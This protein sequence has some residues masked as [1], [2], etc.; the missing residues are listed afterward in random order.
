MSNHVPTFSAHLCHGNLPVAFVF[1]VPGKAEKAQGRPVAEDTGENLDAA[2]ICLHASRPE[3][4]ASVHRY[5]YR[6]T[7]AF[8]K[9][10]AVSLGNAKSE[11][12][13]SE[14]KESRNVSRVVA[15]LDGCNFVILCG[16]K[17][18]LLRVTIAAAGRS[19]IVAPHVGNKG[20]NTSFPTLSLSTGLS[21]AARRQQRV[22]L[23]AQVIL[24]SVPA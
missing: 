13:D 21:T 5:D 6:I 17:A 3:L 23:W 10:I 1:S 7:N 18:K 19:V 12:K 16:R 11:A 20:L 14:I 24:D 15:E 22:E 9:P 8:A 2:L 4:F